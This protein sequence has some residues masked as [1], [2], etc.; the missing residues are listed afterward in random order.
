[1]ST[2]DPYKVEEP[3]LGAL[4]EIQLTP[5]D[6]QKAYDALM[7]KR[8]RDKQIAAEQKKTQETIEWLREGLD[9]NVHVLNGYVSKL[10]IDPVQVLREAARSG[11]THAVVIGWKQDSDEPDNPEFYFASSRPDGAEVLWLL[12]LAR[13]KLMRVGGA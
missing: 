7:E 4:R 6:M 9:S 12:E 5:A 2:Y 13:V 3:N 1:M 11:L 8:H 10:P